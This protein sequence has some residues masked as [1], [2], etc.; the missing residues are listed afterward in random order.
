M[1]NRNT[2]F[3]II[4]C[5][6]PGWCWSFLC[7]LKFITNHIIMLIC[8]HK[9]DALIFRC[10]L[11]RCPIVRHRTVN[12]RPRTLLVYEGNESHVIKNMAATVTASCQLYG[13]AQRDT[14]HLYHVTRYFLLYPLLYGVALSDSVT[15]RHQLQ[16]AEGFVGSICMMNYVTRD[17]W[18]AWHNMHN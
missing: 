18:H 15:I 12:V 11:S 2:H 3:P 10:E 4:Y 13:V 17:K 7:S 6:V 8:L 1:D 5:R 14:V 9:N 16:E